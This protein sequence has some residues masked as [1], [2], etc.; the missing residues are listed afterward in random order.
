MSKA[1]T[2][3]DVLIAPVHTSV[4]SRTFPSLKT[5]ITK[6]WTLDIPIIS[7]N[8]DTITEIDMAFKMAQLGGLGII[9]RFMSTE[10][11]VSQIKEMKLKLGN[12][13][14]VAASVGVKEEGIKRLNHLAEAGVDIITIDIAHGDSILMLEMIN[15]CKNNF[16]NIDVIAGNV[17]M[18]S[19]A[20]KLIEAGADAIKV[21]IGPGSMC[22]TR[23]VT[24]CGIPQLTAIAYCS[25]ICK[26]YDVPLIADGGIKNSGDIVKCFAAGA[27]SV[28]LGSMFS[29]CLETPGE[30]ID[31]MKNYRGMAS[32]DA[33]KHWKG[34][35][36]KGTVAEGVSTLVKAKGSAEEI[37][38]D[39]CGG[40]KSGMSYLNAITIDDIYKNSQFVQITNSSWSESKPHGLN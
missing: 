25:D 27:Q 34:G 32:F 20:E 29:G 16:P 22:T 11:Q 35:L 18:R 6:N 30:I 3:D 33:Q 26:K 36:N 9:H 7:A 8:M 19:A 37:I 21:G 28:M 4:T 5:K 23:I 31:G 12:N 2:F 15:Y 13:Y 38:L 39:L 24:G 10:A 40:I 1:L 17:S 14:P